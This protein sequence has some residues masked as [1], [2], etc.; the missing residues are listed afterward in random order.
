MVVDKSGDLSGAN[1]IIRHDYLPF[2]EE[3]GEGVGIRSSSSG[4]GTDTVRQK[5]TSYERDN[6][7]GLDDVVRI[8]VEILPESQSRTE[9][10]QTLF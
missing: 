7:T 4:Y 5:F 9:G 1:G 2:G 6:E 10:K 3:I 8:L